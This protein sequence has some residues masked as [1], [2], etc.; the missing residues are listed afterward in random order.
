MVEFD[1]I[2]GMYW[3][4]PY[5]AILDCH[6]KTTTLAMPGF[7]WLEWRGTLDYIPSRVV[8]FLK[9]QQMVK[10]GFLAYLAF[11][12]HVSADTPTIESV[13]IVRDFQYVFPADLSGMP[14]D[15]DIDIGIN[16]VPGTQS[17]SIPLYCMALVELKELKEQFQ[18][19]LAFD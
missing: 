8:S 10:K 12:R 19:L 7:P 17:I 4:L 16:L 9:A 3:L 2:L 5:H 14:L 15:K 6:A 13:L 18:E 1:V 11:V